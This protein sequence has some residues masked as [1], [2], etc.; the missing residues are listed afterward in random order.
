MLDPAAETLVRPFET[1]ALEWPEGPVLFLN[2][3]AAAIQN[4]ARVLAVQPERGLFLEL[5]RAGFAPL[6][7]LAGDETGYAAAF[8]LAARQRA[9]NE[10][11]LRLASA[12]VTPGGL[13]V[14]AGA[15]T[16]GID[17]VA[18]A[19]IKTGTPL[20]KPP[21]TMPMSIGAARLLALK[22]PHLKRPRP[23]SCCHPS[24]HFRLVKPMPARAF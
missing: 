24:A 16:S 3:R 17:A 4:P 1:G 2:A 13:I 19:V 23:E 6:T 22:P 18:K 10:A 14:M 5:Q 8:V 9:E 15:K 20:E 12:R 11:N 21:S 7:Q